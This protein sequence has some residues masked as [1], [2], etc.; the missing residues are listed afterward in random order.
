MRAGRVNAWGGVISAGPRSDSPIDASG[1]PEVRGRAEPRAGAR[2]RL[3]PPG[4]AYQ[5]CVREQWGQPT[6]VV[7][8]ASNA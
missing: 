2:G 3:G 6:E 8:S 7:T 5:A 4:C 1:G